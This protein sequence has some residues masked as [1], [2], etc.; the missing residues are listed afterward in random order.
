MAAAEFAITGAK[1]LASDGP[2]TRNIWPKFC[3]FSVLS[4][5]P[6]PIEPVSALHMLFI[7]GPKNISEPKH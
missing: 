5:F 1:N 2:T 7:Y 6:L 3:V 4:G